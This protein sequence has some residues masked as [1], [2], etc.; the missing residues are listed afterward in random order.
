MSKKTE[1]EQVVEGL[2]PEKARAIRSFLSE[3]ENHQ[4]KKVKINNN[5]KR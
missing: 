1:I 5:G 3:I 4:T 2:K